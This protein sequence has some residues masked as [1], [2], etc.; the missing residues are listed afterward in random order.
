MERLIVSQISGQEYLKRLSVSEYPIY[1]EEAILK[2]ER[3]LVIPSR[4]IIHL[5]LLWYPSSHSLYGDWGNGKSECGVEAEFSIAPLNSTYSRCYKCC[6][7]RGLPYEDVFT[8]GPF[9]V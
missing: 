7:I 3:G 9:N 5:P 4:K 6:Y 2:A 8:K 1:N